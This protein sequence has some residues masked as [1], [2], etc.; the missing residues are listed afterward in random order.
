[1]IC[2]G[3]GHF[4]LTTCLSISGLDHGQVFALDIEMR[5]YWDEQ[6]LRKLPH[7]DPTIREFFR[8]R[9]ADELPWRPWGYEN[10]YHVADSF[11]DF[12]SKLQSSE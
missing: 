6:T 8:L 9:D 11:T 12:L 2:I 4:G 3:Y 5:F 10:C 7:L 1:M